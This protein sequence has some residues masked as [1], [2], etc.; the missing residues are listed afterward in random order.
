MATEEDMEEAGG[1]ESR[2]VGLKKGIP[3]I[4]LDG[5]CELEIM[6]QRLM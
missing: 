6:L 5:A 3:R 2:R 4:K 1:G